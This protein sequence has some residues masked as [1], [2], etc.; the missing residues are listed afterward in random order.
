MSTVN[1]DN[2]SVGV[3]IHVSYTD[4]ENLMYS[5]AQGSSYWCKY[6]GDLGYESTVHEILEKKL[7]LKLEDFEDEKARHTL[8]LAK[9]K[10]GLTIMANKYP[11]HFASILQ[12][13]TDADTADVLLQCALLGEIVYG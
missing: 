9:I 6:A 10:K 8:T 5:M 13:N 1:W 12:D 3:R 7:E 2:K 4:I 11:K